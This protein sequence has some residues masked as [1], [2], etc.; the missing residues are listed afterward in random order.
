MAQG[1]HLGTLEGRIVPYNSRSVGTAFRR[2]CVE[3]SVKDLHFRDLR[4]EGTSRLFKAG[5]A[6][7]QVSLVTGRKDWT[8][9]RR[10]PQLRPEALHR[11]AA[12]GAPF[13][14]D[15]LAAE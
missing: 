3:V 5:V 9:L 14:S 6:I 4:H 8:M 11:L 13:P 2:A 12:S 7:E 15:N 10:Y 1:K